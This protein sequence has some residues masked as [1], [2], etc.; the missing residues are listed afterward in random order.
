MAN[1]QSRDPGSFRNIQSQARIGGVPSFAVDTGDASRALADVAGSLSSKLKT[2]ADRAAV[3][4]AEMAGLSAGERGAVSYM[5]SRAAEQDA[6]TGTRSRP[7]RGQVNAPA[8]IRS[9]IVE[10]AQRHGQDPAKLLKIAE[11]ESSFNPAA[12]NSSS[13]AGG[14]F[15]FIDGTAADYGL[16]NRFDPVEASDAGARLLRDNR[17]YLAKVLGREPTVGE[18]YLAHQQGKGGAAKLLSNP[19]AK[20]V[21]LVGAD[22]VKLNGG[23]KDMTA[24]EFAGLWL[25]KAGDEPGDVRHGLPSLNSQPLALRRD[26]TIS[27][28]AFDAAATRAYSWRMAEGL[29]TDLANAYDD[30]G[31]D[32]SGFADRLDEIEKRYLADPSLQDPELREAF[33]KSFA[34]QSR[35]YRLN[36]ASRQET[37]LKAE[38]VAAAEGAFS[39]RERDLERQAHALG[40]NPEGDEILSQQLARAGDMV[41]AAVEAGTI[42]P[43]Q[44]QRQKESLGKTAARARVQGVF[45]ALETPA[46]KE[47][48]AL[49]LLEDWQTGEGPLAA[50]DFSTV[51]ALSQTL[52][53]DA[54]AETNRKDATTKLQKVRIKDLLKDDIA[55]IQRT[56]KPVDFTAAGF[57]DETVLSALTPEEYETWREGRDLAGRVYEAVADLETLSADDIE[58]RLELLE[59]DP[60]S[61]GF[62]DQEAVLAAAEK[63]AADVIKLRARDP[64][65]AVEESFP[66]VA[67][68]ADLADPEAPETLVNLVQARLEA[69]G[70]LDIPELARQ[71]LTVEEAS[72]LARAIKSGD[73][74]SQAA[75]MNELVGQIQAAY[76]PHAD[77][78]LQQVLEVRGI[79]KD[80]ARYGAAVFAKVNK[81]DRPSGSD[82]AAAR[83]SSEATASEQ[84]FG[85]RVDPGTDPVP[86]YRA[87][88]D[89]LN[90]PDLAAQFDEKYGTGAAARI[91]DARPADPYR[92]KVEGGIEY[93][94]ETGEG[95]IPDAQ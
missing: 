34:Q 79:D 33:Q 73:A 11:L 12:K 18:L 17:A 86:P 44:G 54:R 9:S 75:A 60:G 57:D 87:V 16:K 89:L 67:E 51:K 4:E 93:V 48:F 26:G 7:S 83:V 28:D 19:D 5:Q 81:L 41:D 78:V 92:R 42:T 68:L 50:L 13:S 20:A 84:S 56:G 23:K 15:Q 1:R 91:L 32:P 22:A 95:F 66:E 47:Q 24:A 77:Q 52:Y 40:A 63:K 21:D 25:R 2:L 59:P 46:Q 55:S 6:P 58:R 80:L 62:R 85:A 69:Q 35:S 37:R 3:R 74:S 30:F 43:L 8:H 31:D 70:A 39:A 49:S 45:D 14:L 90:N 72:N 29:S 64:A 65:R 61:P 27:G 88:Q 71:P 10:A 94:D 76:G 53:R 82:Q 36:V 38:E